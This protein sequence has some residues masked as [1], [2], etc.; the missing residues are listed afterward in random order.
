L[1]R[2]GELPKQVAPFDLGR[3][4]WLV[5]QNRPGIFS[6]LD[7]ALV[8]RSKPAFTVTKFGVPLMWIYPY[9]DFERLRAQIAR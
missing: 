6:N 1:R 5:L 4:I 2:T 3:P 7:R 9:S 8:A